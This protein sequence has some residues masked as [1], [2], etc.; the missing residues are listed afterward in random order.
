MW[1]SYLWQCLFIKSAETKQ[2]KSN[3]NLPKLQI[4]KEIINYLTVYLG[5]GICTEI[6]FAVMVE[7]NSAY[8]LRITSAYNSNAKV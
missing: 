8:T 7:G 1:T 2:Y 3:L 5:S 4:G 6:V